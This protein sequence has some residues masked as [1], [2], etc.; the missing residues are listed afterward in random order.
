MN[1][2]VLECCLL[3]ELPCVH[4][5]PKIYSYISV[6][7]CSFGMGVS[8]STVKYSIS[9]FK[10]AAEGSRNAAAA[11]TSTKKENDH[12][13]NSFST[14]DPLS[15]PRMTIDILRVLDIRHMW[16]FQRPMTWCHLCVG[17]SCSLLLG[18]YCS[19]H[20]TFI[21]KVFCAF[22]EFCGGF[23]SHCLRETS[24]ESEGR[25]MAST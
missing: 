1:K 21:W 22:V 11:D 19:F 16:L 6:I 7:I 4:H 17:H 23:G 15:A 12:R 2:Y 9:S 3:N 5:S 14:T 13:P 25:V 24:N 18:F 10:K 20:S 8:F